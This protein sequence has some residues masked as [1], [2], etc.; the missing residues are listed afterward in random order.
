MLRALILLVYFT[1]IVNTLPSLPEHDFSKTV[2]D[3]TKT[4]IINGVKT[5]TTVKKVFVKLKEGSYVYR[6]KRVIG[7]KSAGK[8]RAQF[9]CTSCEQ[10]KTYTSC[11][12]TVLLQEQE[13]DDEYHLEPDSYPHPDNHA[14]VLSG[15]EDQV[16]KFHEQVLDE[17]RNDPCQAIPALYQ[18]TR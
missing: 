6:K 11:F 9:V 1:Y 13:E 4:I 18:K 3:G 7:K 5:K 16:S 17:L 2:Q 12:A 10:M 15:I 14:C 8:V